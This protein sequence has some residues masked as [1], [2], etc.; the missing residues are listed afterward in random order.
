MLVARRYRSIRVTALH[1]MAF[2]AQHRIRCTI[3]PPIAIIII[4]VNCQVIDAGGD[5][6][7]TVC[8]GASPP[9]AEEEAAPEE[10]QAEEVP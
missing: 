4:L 1:N 8:G 6:L 5:A 2:T 7:Y 9:L 10:P 3:C